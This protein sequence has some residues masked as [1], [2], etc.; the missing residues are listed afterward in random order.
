MAERSEI[1]AT[2]LGTID[3]MFDLKIP[4]GD[5][6]DETTLA[7]IGMDSLDLLEAG[8]EL[9]ERFHVALAQEDFEGVTN[10]GLLID[11]FEARVNHA[12]SAEL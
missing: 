3:E 6:V 12:S 5:I 2:V 4:V 1:V 8:M 10:F 9:E 7:D 11:V